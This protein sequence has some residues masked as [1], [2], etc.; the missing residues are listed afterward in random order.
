MTYP[1]VRRHTQGP[2]LQSDGMVERG[3][4]A[5]DFALPGIER[6]EPAVYQLFEAIENDDHVV[7]WFFPVTFLPT[8]TAELCAIRDAGWHDVDGIQVWAISMDS[9]YAGAA[10]AD[11]YDL[12]MAILGDGA[13]AAEYYDV[14]YEEWEGHYGVPKRAA[15]LVGTDW[16]VDARW[17]TDDAFDPSTPSPVVEIGD[18]LAES[19]DV[20]VPKVS[21]DAYIR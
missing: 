4:K 16:N 9:I 11:E 20:D 21:Y 19:I 3:Q 10:Y 2:S 8:A 14:R 17:V 7:L 6:A 15:F 5:P 13:S 12:P 18:V 1:G